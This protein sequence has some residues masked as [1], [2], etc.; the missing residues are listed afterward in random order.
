ML[1]NESCLGTPHPRSV[2]ML[3]LSPARWHSHLC[4]SK[5]PAHFAGRA[6]LCGA[7]HCGSFNSACLLPTESPCLLSQ[8]GLWAR[9]FH[10]IFWKN[11]GDAHPETISSWNLAVAGA[12]EDSER[13]DLPSSSLVP[14]RQSYAHSPG[15]VPAAI[16]PRDLH[17]ARVDCSYVFSF[18]PT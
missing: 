17:T 7:P 11:C 18:L 14:H 2:D 16:E 12:E 13:A 15:R 10:W 6:T 4:P 1:R 9:P 8:F 5:T 3:P